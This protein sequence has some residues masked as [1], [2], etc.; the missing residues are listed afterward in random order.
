MALSAQKK[1]GEY[2]SETMNKLEMEY[3]KRVLNTMADVIIYAYRINRFVGISNQN[4]TME[5]SDI[6]EEIVT[7]ISKRI[8]ALTDTIQ[9][10][11]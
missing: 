10:M 3:E 1:N 6:M 5:S 8:H 4:I 11:N 2:M 9:R 7:L